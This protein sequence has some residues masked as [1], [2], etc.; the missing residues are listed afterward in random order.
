[1]FRINFVQALRPVT[2]LLWSGVINNALIVDQLVMHLRPDRFRHCQPVPVRLEP[3]VCQPLRLALLARDQP[4]DVFVQSRRRRIG[5]DV[6][7]KSI[8]VVL[9]DQTLD[10]FGGSAHGKLKCASEALDWFGCDQA[11]FAAEQSGQNPRMD[12]SNCVALKPRGSG[13]AWRALSRS[14]SK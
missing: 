12:T 13:I 7:V 14:M 9:F 10:G 6:R 1:Q 4:D 5:F 2:F 3:P 11:F 8:L